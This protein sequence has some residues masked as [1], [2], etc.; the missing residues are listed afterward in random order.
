MTNPNTQLTG[1]T[2]GR[3]V[4]FIANEC[5]A[6]QPADFAAAARRAQQ[7][8]IDTI[9]PKRANGTE[10]WYGDASRLKAESDAVRA[11]GVGYLPFSYCYG[12]AFGLGFVDAECGILAEMMTTLGF[13]CADLEVEWDNRPDA[14]AR[15]NARMS[16]VPG[17][18]YLTTWADPVQQGWAS[19]T[20]ALAPCVNAWIPQ[21]YSDWLAAQSQQL[22]SLG[23]TTIQP[24]IDITSEFGANH[25]ADIALQAAQRGE[26]TIWLWEYLPAMANR[27]LTQQI[28]SIMPRIGTTPPPS[29]ALPPAPTVAHTYTVQPGDTL[30]AIAE[31]LGIPDWHTLYYANQATIGPDP[32]LIHPGDVLTY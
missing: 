23:E 18:L 19:V 1:A 9:A 14:A 6:W 7:L 16:P 13:A 2:A 20:R 8:G 27:Q 32:D 21:Q 3:S 31:K 17:L 11:E 22:I 28:A 10:R 25:P 4:L 30:S 15:F 5:A 12:P 29:P 24:A 26:T